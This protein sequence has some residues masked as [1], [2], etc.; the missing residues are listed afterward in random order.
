MGIAGSNATGGGVG[1]RVAGTVDFERRRALHRARAKELAPEV[2]ALV[3]TPRAHLEE[4]RQ[5]ALRALLNR[6]VQRSEWYRDRF[7]GLE[8]ES[9]RLEE[10]ASLPTMTKSDLMTNFDAVA[11]DPRVTLERC[12]A[13]IASDEPYMD[14]DLLV[15]AS[16]GTSGVRAIGVVDWECAART[17]TALPR[18]LLR[19]ARRT[20]RIQGPPRTT[21]IAAGP[22]PHASF[23]LGRV[24]GFGDPNGPRLSVLQP[25]E[26][27]V[28]ALNRADPDHVICYAS[29]LPHLLEE[30]RAGRLRNRPRVVT[31]AAEPLADEHEHALVEEWGSAVLSSW[32]ATEV[33]LLGGGTG[34]DSGMLLYDDLLIIEPVDADGRPVPAGTRCAKLFVTP[35]YRTALP[36]VR[37]EL[38]DQLT[39]LDEPASC[40]SAFTRVTNV[41]GRLEEEFV[42]RGGPSVHPH[43]F[44]D[45]LGRNPAFRSY[46]VEQTPRGADVRIIASTEID[47]HGVRRELE[48]RLARLGLVDPEVRVQRVTEL[49]RR[50]AASKL[51]RFL[52]L[53]RGSRG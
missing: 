16:G 53:V 31:P 39:V 12:E 28:A 15:M 32:G 37:Y 40:G 46:Q 13:H 25:L 44:G 7:A 1:I 6:C 11:T 34:F 41:V 26:E 24:F 42:Y 33:G 35:L 8:P 2:A 27:I 45:V 20:G 51:S 36:L 10:L 22:G 17:S 29:L 52:P 3:D 14:S 49:P 48:E 5:S 50:G 47:A 21:V 38:T 23:V 43:V 30:A 4:H 9:F 19:W 18:F